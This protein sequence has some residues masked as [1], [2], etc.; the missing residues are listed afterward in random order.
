MTTAK[1]AP[2]MSVRLPND[3]KE[4]I[5]AEAGRNY[6]SLN[7]EIVVRLKQCMDAEKRKAPSVA[8]T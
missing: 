6:R 4:W 7:A 8:T 1:S 3:L 5:A 2:S